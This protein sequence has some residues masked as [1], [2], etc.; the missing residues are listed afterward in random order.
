MGGD[1]DIVISDSDVAGG[2]TGPGVRN[3]DLDPLFADLLG[4]DGLAGTEDD[5]MRLTSGSPCI[6][7]GDPGFVP[8]PGERDL[9]GHA[10]VLCGRVDMGAYEFRIGDF[11]CSRNVDLADYAEFPACLAGPNGGLGPRCAAFD[12]DFDG[13]VDLADLAG[14]Q[15]IYE[16]STL[17]P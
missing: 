15:R 2:W 12:F 7:A 9:D 4:P 17:G 1:A 14:F 13:D 6:D 11:D 16:A 8:A 5:D 10:R 3:I